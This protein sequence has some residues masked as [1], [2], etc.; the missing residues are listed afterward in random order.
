MFV[1][2]I[3]EPPD[4]V[5]VAPLSEPVVED[6]EFTLT[7]DIIDVAPIKNLTV[8]WYRGNENVHTEVFNDTS[9]TPQNVTSTLKVIAK[10]SYNGINFTCKAELH[11]GPNG[12]E[13]VPTVTSE[14]RVA[15]VHCEFSI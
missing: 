9:V 15:V 12:P 7:C 8:T 3:K 10:R 1:C 13:L 14:P 11:L 6:T 4:I 5:S 2:F